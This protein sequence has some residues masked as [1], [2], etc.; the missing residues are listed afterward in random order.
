MAKAKEY[1]MLENIA[2]TELAGFM[3]KVTDCEYM[4][5]GKCF[6]ITTP[7]AGQV[8]FM[9]DRDDNK[10]GKPATISIFGKFDNE[11]AARALGFDCNMF[12][13]KWNHHFEYSAAGIK[14]IFEE[15]REKAY[16]D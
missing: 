7:K 6:T 8:D 12:S 11:K 14:A 15:L 4:S 9:I 2:V 13:G 16:G 10:Y 1:E 3:P 5:H